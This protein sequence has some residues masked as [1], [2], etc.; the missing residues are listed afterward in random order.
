MEV[1]R[2]GVGMDAVH[3]PYKGGGQAVADVIAGHI[4]VTFAATQVAKGLVENGKLKAIAVDERRALARAARRADARGS[5]VAPADV[6]LRFWYG[7]FGPK[8]IPEAAKAKLERGVATVMADPKVRERLAKLDI[9]P[10]TRPARRSA[11]SS[12][13]RSATGPRSST[14]RT[15]S[16]SDGTKNAARGPWIDHFGDNFLCRTRRSSSRAWRPM[17]SLRSRRWTACARSCARASR[18]LMP[19]GRSG[20]RWPMQWKRAPRPRKPQATG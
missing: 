7:V 14:R 9:T 5:G 8:G 6:D 4:P 1:F 18:S 17:A 15:S 19:G 12:R 2:D 10:S 11:R 13:P 3:V 16:R 20:A